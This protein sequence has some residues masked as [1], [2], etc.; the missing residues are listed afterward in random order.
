MIAVRI[1]SAFL[2]LC[3]GIFLSRTLGVVSVGIFYGLFGLTQLIAAISR[4]GLGQTIVSKLSYEFR[5]NK[6]SPLA[7]AVFLSAKKTTRI[8][9]LFASLASMAIPLFTPNLFE[10]NPITLFLCTLTISFF[11]LELSMNSEWFRAQGKTVISQFIYPLLPNLLFLLF[12]FNSNIQSLSK[13]IVYYALSYL[14]VTI[15]SNLYLFLFQRDIKIDNSLTQEYTSKIETVASHIL[16][17]ELTTLMNTWM[18]S[19]FLPQ[20]APAGSNIA[21][22]FSASSRAA[23]PLQILQASIGYW[24]SPK[25]GGESGFSKERDIVIQRTRRTHLLLISLALPVYLILMLLASDIMT[26][27]GTDFVTGANTF[28]IIITA[29][30]ISICFGPCGTL[31]N[32]CGYASSNALAS[33]F[34]LLVF[35]LALFM[36]SISAENV[37]LCVM[38]SMV[39]RQLMLAAYVRYHL[40]FWIYPKL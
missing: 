1:A 14:T 15:A 38:L 4:R 9:F 33:V 11:S 22:L 12:I 37:A 19:I 7:K 29:Y 40:A 6:K 28:R 25:I 32:M 34:S 26:L 36:V 16:L 24:L 5:D 18:P 31:L 21:G 27:F 30:V 35:L 20:L 2:Q 8:T 10:E 13:A 39:C 3:V 17:T 23:R